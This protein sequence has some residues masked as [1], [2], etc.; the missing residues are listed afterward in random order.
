MPRRY[1]PDYASAPWHITN[2][3]IAKR[4]ALENGHDIAQ[5]VAL[6]QGD[7]RG[8]PDR[9]PRVRGLDHAVPPARAQP[10][11][12]TAARAARAPARPRA[13]VPPLSQARGRAL[14]PLIERLPHGS[15]DD[16]TLRAGRLRELAG[17]AIA[18]LAL[19]LDGAVATA[20]QRVRA[21]ER[22]S[23]D[24]GADCEAV[25]RVVDIGVRRSVSAPACMDPSPTWRRRCRWEAPRGT[26]RVGGSEEAAEETFRVRQ[27]RR[28]RAPRA[29]R[30]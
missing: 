4:T 13:L 1:P 28:S 20:H 8:G 11:R 14:A 16:G 29:F 2:R 6:L 10:P 19:R 12:R 5:F 30:A 7:R 26:S 25:A 3:G 24:D 18:E 15:R 23:E 9:D 22:R 17:L 27:A 21:H